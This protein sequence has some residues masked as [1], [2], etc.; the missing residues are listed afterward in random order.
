[1]NSFGASPLRLALREPQLLIGASSSQWDEFVRQARA[2]NLLPRIATS[3]DELGLLHEVPTAPR[4]HLVAAGTL[5][6]AQADAVRREVAHV[7]GALAA[8]GVSFILLKGAAYLLA[9]LRAARGRMFSDIDILVPRRALPD[10][11]AA[12]MLSGWASA[13]ITAYDQRYYR[14]WMH[15]LPPL[16]HISR[17]T[18]LDVHHAILPTTARLKP[19]S[20]K[21]LAASL[22]VAGKPHLRVLAPPDMVLHSATHLFCNEDV[23]NSLRD[24]V[25]LDSLVRDFAQEIGF[26]PGLTVRAAELDLTRPLYYALRYL[27]PILDTPVP[28][29]VLR[30]A[31]I[32]RPS[33]ML[34][35]LMDALF[36]RTLQ[37]ERA[38]A[39]NGLAA[40]ARGAVYVRAHWLRMPP[41]LLAC[42]LAVKAVTHE[43]TTPL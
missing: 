25:D 2:A 35:G 16:K 24:L 34:R 21:L 15:E 17:R 11:E 43:Q 5:A 40:L 9:G 32:G 29:Q 8:T 38:G 37:P 3:L 42:H 13:N 4:A 23:G 20:A 33:A 14:R 31:E 36:M 10:V 39:T 41:H 26:W 22:P 7:E 27:V 1:M 30:D 28:A 12:L 19:D 6:Q 18:L